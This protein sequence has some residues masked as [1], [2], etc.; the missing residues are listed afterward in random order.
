MKNVEARERDTFD[1]EEL[2]ERLNI[3]LTVAYELAKADRLPIP[4]IRVG[5]QY[6]FSRKAYERLMHAQHGEPANAADVA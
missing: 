4:T 5:R 2:S 3:S 1:L 6:R